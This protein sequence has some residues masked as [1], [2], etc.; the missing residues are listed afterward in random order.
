MVKK[1]KREQVHATEVQIHVYTKMH[2]QEA[3]LNHLNK[4]SF[5]RVELQKLVSFIQRKRRRMLDHWMVAL[6]WV[7]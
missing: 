2:D 3:L 6:F 1:K 5:Q 4:N 7:K